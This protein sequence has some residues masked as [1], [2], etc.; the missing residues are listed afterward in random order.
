MT[1]CVCDFCKEKNADRRYKV[2]RTYLTFPFTKNEKVDICD[3]CYI[4]LFVKKHEVCD[5]D[6]LKEK[7]KKIAD[8]YKDSP[9]AYEQGK[10]FAYLNAIQTIDN[11]LGG[12]K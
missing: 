1:K 6:G 7:F 11:S 2:K 12:T 10:A 4:K 5:V 9:D 3:D 8:Y